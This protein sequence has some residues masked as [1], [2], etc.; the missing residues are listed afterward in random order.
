MWLHFWNLLCRSLRYTPSIISSNWAGILLPAI[1]F[2]AREFVRARKEGWRTMNWSAIG[3]DT[4]WMIG[5]YVCLFTWAVIHTIY[6]DHQNLLKEV[7]IATN[8]EKNAEERLSLLTSPHL[9]GAIG[10]I[11]IAPAG[12]NDRNVL[13]TVL[14]TITNSGAPSVAQLEDASLHLQSGER[15]QVLPITLPSPSIN[16]LRSDGGAPITLQSKDYLP[17]KAMETPIVSGGA[18]SGFFMGVAEG[19]TKEQALSSGTVIRLQFKDIKGNVL[20]N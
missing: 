15:V 17:V 19:V 2:I 20:V 6:T 18:C 9:E 10:A 8:R 5:L 7:E 13:V 16:L 3:R 1:V 14:A 12:K 11:S 4:L